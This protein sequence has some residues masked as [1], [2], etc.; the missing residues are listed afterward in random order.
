VSCVTSSSEALWAIESFCAE[1][2]ICSEGW[3]CRVR[4]SGSTSLKGNTG[5]WFH[6]LFF[7]SRNTTLQSSVAYTDTFSLH[8]SYSCSILLRSHRNNCCDFPFK[9]VTSSVRVVKYRNLRVTWHV[10]RKEKETY[11][12]SVRMSLE[13]IKW[14]HRPILPS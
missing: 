5:N 14:K 2:C 9:Q 7:C 10:A 13:W 11:W 3:E 8:K 6:Y 12:L 1:V 4:K